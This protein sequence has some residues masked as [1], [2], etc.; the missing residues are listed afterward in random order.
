MARGQ[1]ADRP[2]VPRV[3]LRGGLGRT[4]LTA[5][6]FLAIL[7]LSFVSWFATQRSR[8][9]IQGEVM[10]KLASIAVLKE[11]QISRWGEEQAAVLT[12]PEIDAQLETT[13]RAVEVGSD[14]ARGL[15]AEVAHWWGDADLALLS[16]EGQVEWA[17]DATWEGDALSLP[18]T[19][20]SSPDASA[21]R[22]S[23]D[24]RDGMG[25]VLVSPLPE[26]VRWPYVAIRLPADELARILE[27]TAGLGQTGE[28]YVVDG[29]GRVLP[30]GRRVSGPAIET[31][32]LGQGNQGLYEN[33][34]GVS[35][36]GVYR[37]LPAIGLALFVEQSQE[38]A[39]AGNDA[40]V[41]AVIAITLGV[42]LVTAVIAAF[43]TR[44]FTRPLVTL[45]ESALNI[46]AGDLSQRVEFTS[47]DEIGILA[48]V[49]D[50]MAA[51]LEVL[52]GNLEAKVAERTRRLQQANYQIQRRA[53]Q[54]QASLE[55]GRAVT[56]ILDP[57]Q[58]LEQVVRVVRDR[59]VYSYVGVYTVDRAGGI[60]ALRASAGD[61]DPFHG[62]SAPV[63]LPGPVGRAFREGRAM[64]ESRV[65]PAV[66]GPPAHY[67]RS[68]VTV[69]LRLG[70]R[71]LGVLDVQTTDEE[72][73]DEDDVSVLQ[74]VANQ[75][76]IAL[77]N[78]RAYAVE[79][80]AAAWLRELDQ[81]KRRFL[82]NMSHEFRTPLT[83]IIGFSRLMLKGI[84]GELTER[85]R[86]D[87][88]II[89]QNS[90]HLLGLINDLLD[91][92]Q[93][94][95]G[96]M[97]LE[98]RSVNLADLIHSVMATASALVRDKEVVLREEI[99]PDLPEVMADPSR[100]R[101][102]LLRLLANAAKF[103]SQGGIT[104]RAQPTDGHVLVSVSD[105]GVGIPPEDRERIFAR[106]EQGT[107]EN[108]RRPNGAGLGLALSKEFVEMHGG[109]MWVESEVGKGS[110]FTFSLPLEPR[111]GRDEA[112]TEGES[113][114]SRD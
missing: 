33:Y 72:G 103:T 42:A 35:V 29:A 73:F 1:E 34:D 93:I 28:A 23:I 52:Y 78:A 36:I 27:E 77:E 45:T 67:T 94:E 87:L 111:T 113:G 79:R 43:V 14:E 69:P 74:N 32:L 82:A 106:F 95:A 59:F 53:I 3:G 18:R 65:L 112:R 30:Q 56:S 9:N 41:A 63:S 6:L 20:S 71:T 55:V 25:L 91:V 22:A 110:T 66:V 99:A 12:A 5:F 76:T 92:S 70:D 97:E 96:L 4:L 24:L 47:H 15:L 21:V 68:E 39:F 37:W 8:L 105:T 64:L 40:V 83:N 49:F 114:R 48:H 81:S 101:Q 60:L 61:P 17:S 58:L 54:M 89:H 98:F 46:A 19:A 75:I 102:V 109:Q 50:R 7:P 62:Q 51:E 31:A 86:K 10:D 57:D 90:Q 84:D 104:V 44:Q 26:S 80:E 100:I 16:P 88:Q 11:A 107:L 108:G 13:L 38:E 2:E 85:Q